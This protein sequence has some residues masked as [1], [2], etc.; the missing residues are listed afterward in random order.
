MIKRPQCG[1]TRLAARLV[2]A[3]RPISRLFCAVTFIS[4]VCV[5]S[6]ALGQKENPQ[7]FNL[8]LVGDA[9]IATPVMVH[10]DDPRFMG[11]VNAVR[12]GDAAAINFEGTFASEAAYPVAD[13][14]GTS[15]IER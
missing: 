11:V 13:T 12:K 9:I 2:C 15:A 10:Q 7:E 5:P 6:N 14:G 1:L 4:L 3:Y 8:T